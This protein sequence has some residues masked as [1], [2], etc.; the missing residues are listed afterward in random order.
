MIFSYFFKCSTGNKDH[1]PNF[2]NTK[3]TILKAMENLNF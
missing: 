3:N 2:L 1:G